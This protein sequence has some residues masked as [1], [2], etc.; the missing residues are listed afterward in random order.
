MKNTTT[1]TTK[2]TSKIKQHNHDQYTSTQVHKYQVPSTQIIHSK[3]IKH[4]HKR[5]AMWPGAGCCPTNPISQT[6]FWT[7]LRVLVQYCYC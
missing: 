1:K 3:T 6:G 7:H 2:K 5:T 4:K